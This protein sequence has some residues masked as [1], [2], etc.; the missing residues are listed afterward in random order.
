[1]VMCQLGYIFLSTTLV[2]YDIKSVM[3][4]YVVMFVKMINFNSMCSMLA[5]ILEVLRTNKFVTISFYSFYDE[6]H[7]FVTKTEPK[8]DHTQIY[9]EIQKCH[10]K[11]VIN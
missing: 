3:N 4:T 7:I 1:M 6:Y 11:F 8:L 2:K 9:D 5:H 10:A